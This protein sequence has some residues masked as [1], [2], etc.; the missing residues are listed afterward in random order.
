MR[1]VVESAEDHAVPAIERALAPAPG[2][3]PTRD[4]RARCWVDRRRFRTSLPLSR[5]VRR[6]KCWHSPTRTDDPSATGSDSSSL[7]S[8]RAGRRRRVELSLLP[9]RARE[10][11]DALALGMERGGAHGSRGPRSQLRLGRSDGDPPGR[12]SADWSRGGLGGRSL[13]RLRDDPRRAPRGPPGRVRPFLPRRL[14][15]RRRRRGARV[16]VRAAADDYPR[17]LARALRDRRRHS[18]DLRGV[19][20]ARAPSGTLSL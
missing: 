19:P 7:R 3:G 18:S 13:G 17:V 9:S 8:T 10:L 12:V 20:R 6:P 15:R 11:R 5:A 1:L 14:A 16:L 2:K 4:R